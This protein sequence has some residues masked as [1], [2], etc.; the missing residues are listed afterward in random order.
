MRVLKISVLPLMLAMLV[1]S[2]CFG[3]SQPTDTQIEKMS[4]DFFNQ[5]FKGLFLADKVIKNNGYKK[6]DTNYVAELSVMA[7][8]QLS[9]EDYAK[10]TLNDPDLSAMDKMASTMAIGMMKMTLPE[11]SAGDTVEFKRDY[12]FIKTDNGWLIKEDLTQA[13]PHVF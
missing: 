12:L 4:G 7:K 6:N 2:G 1:L 8:A 11:F 3:V 5:E 10:A 9:L 13:S